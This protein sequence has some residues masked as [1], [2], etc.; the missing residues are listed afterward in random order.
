MSHEK[1]RFALDASMPSRSLAWLFKQ[2][3]LHLINIREANSEVFSPKQFTAPATTILMLVND[4]ILLLS[5]FTKIM[6]QGI[7]KRQ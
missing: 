5:A 4:A 6:G 3:H 2:I 7:Q 1:H